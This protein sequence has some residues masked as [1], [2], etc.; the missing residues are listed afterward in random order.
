MKVRVEEF[1]ELVPVCV[2]VCVCECMFVWQ[3]C[4]EKCIC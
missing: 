2:C 4:N 1:F 3:S